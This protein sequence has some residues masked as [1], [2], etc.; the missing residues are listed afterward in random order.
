MATLYCQSSNNKRPGKG[1]VNLTWF[2]AGD[3]PGTPANWLTTTDQ[4]VANGWAEAHGNANWLT[5]ASIASFKAQYT[6]P[7]KTK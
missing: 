3:S 1:G 6:A 5:K 2:L 4:N 7:V